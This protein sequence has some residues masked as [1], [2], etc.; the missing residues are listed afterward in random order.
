MDSKMFSLEGKVVVITGAAGLLG[1]QHAEAV[2][3]TGGIPVL[4][5]L[6]TKKV[7]ALASALA[8]SYGV[9]ASGYTV[10]ITDENAVKENVTEVLAHYGRIDGLIN[11]A[12]NNPKVTNTG[13]VNFTRLESLPMEAWMADINVG[14]TGA[15]LCLKHYGSAIARQGGSIINISSDLGLI[16]PDQR[17]YRREGIDEVDQ[18]VKPI[19]YSA[20][21]SGVIGLTR[22]VATYWASQGVRCN[23]ICPGGVEVDQNPAFIR[24]LSSRIP[25]GRMAQPNEYQGAVVFLL[26]NAS[27]YMN[28]SVLAIDG[29]RT[30]W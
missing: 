26:S 11:N 5:D 1:E 18:P 17:L 8:A 24:D 22:Y 3:A 13:G 19:T 9:D 29:G 7:G 23:V 14:L 30:C 10:D 21:K 12:A 6:D 27:S 25:M 20:V 15:F 4:L 28:G 2:S 16:A